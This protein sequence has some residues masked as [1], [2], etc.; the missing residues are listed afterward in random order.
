MAATAAAAAAGGCCGGNGGYCCC[1]WLLWRQRRL[2]L[3]LVGVA[4]VVVAA[5]AAGGGRE[6]EVS[7]GVIITNTEIKFHILLFT[8]HEVQVLLLSLFRLIFSSHFIVHCSDSLS[9]NKGIIF[10]SSVISIRKDSGSLL[11]S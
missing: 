7:L 1:W 8:L 9:S 3:L 2:L 4:G 10:S 6:E 11:S 5:A